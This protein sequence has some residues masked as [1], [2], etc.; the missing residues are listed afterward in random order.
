MP[1]FLTYT[2]TATAVAATTGESIAGAAPG[3]LAVAIAFAFVLA[4]LVGAL[5]Q[6]SG[7]HLNPAVTLGLAVIGKFPWRYT[8]AY[9]PF[10]LAG[11]ILGAAAT[12][13]TLGSRAREEA[14]L[15]RRTPPRASAM[16]TRAFTPAESD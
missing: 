9:M 2:G 3:S 8:P 14:S 12:W 6:V 4:A 10:Q 16:V 11:A 1:A 13:L 15:G 5:G 7:A